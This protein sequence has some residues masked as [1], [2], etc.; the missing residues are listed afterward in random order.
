MPKLERICESL[1]MKSVGGKEVAHPSF[2]LW[3]TS[4]PTPDF[5]VLILQNG[6]KM[7]NEPPKGL[8]AN[9][10]GTYK[11][12]PISDPT[13][14]N[15]HSKLGVFKKLLYGLCMFHAII[16][17]RRNYGA[18]GWNIR[19]EF[20]VSDLQISIKQLQNFT[21][22]YAQVPYKALKYLTGECNYGGRVTDERDRRVL[23]A[24]LEEFYQPDLFQERFQPGGL[25][26]YEFPNGNIHYNKYLDHIQRMPLEE[27]PSLFGFHPNANITKEIKE[28]FD[29][30]YDLLKMG[31]IDGVK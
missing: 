25:A 7:T 29:L 26:D 20:T 12:E 22:D 14:F 15:I 31:E 2:R 9:M 5:P 4:Y 18:L 24:L 8:K 10:I 21:N 1:D 30:C 17:E 28:T 27:P 19:Y 3:L 11:Q 13:F 23:N 6:I 16:Q